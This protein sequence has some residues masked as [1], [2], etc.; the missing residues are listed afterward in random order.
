MLEVTVQQQHDRILEA[1]RH[2]FIETPKMGGDIY[3]SNY[4]FQNM[5]EQI[6]EAYIFSQN[7]VDREKPLC[8][9]SP[10]Q[11]CHCTEHMDPHCHQGQ[12][13]IETNNG[14]A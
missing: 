5:E 7:H 2:Q 11:P 1:C 9:A 6:A 10:P 3:S 12:W 14:C 8:L 4:L 13:E